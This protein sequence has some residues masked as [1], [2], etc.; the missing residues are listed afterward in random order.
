MLPDPL[1]PAVVHLP[2]A[3]SLLMPLLALCAALAIHREM[4]P[5][6]IWSGLVLLSFLL[7]AGS[8]A[9]LET[10]EHEEERVE[11]AVAESLVEAHEEAAELFIVIAGAFLLVCLAGLSSGRTGDLARVASV[12]LAIGLLISG[13]QVGHRGGELVYRHGAASAYTDS[14]TGGFVSGAA[15]EER[16]HRGEH[17]HDDEGD[18]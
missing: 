11:Q 8:W 2:I 13:V 16:R 5:R 3:L 18:D 17:E 4:M 9:A 6:Q 7:V 15:A 14:K 10:G 12:P 1:H